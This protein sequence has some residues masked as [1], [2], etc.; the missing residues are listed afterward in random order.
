MANRPTLVTL[1][2]ST[3]LL[4]MLVLASDSALSG[5][6]EARGHK[7]VGDTVELVY[8]WKP[9]LTLYVEASSGRI[10][11]HFLPEPQRS[12]FSIRYV[13]S[14]VAREG[15]LYVTFSD[16]TTERGTPAG[17]DKASIE[18]MTQLT[19]LVPDFLVSSEG[20]FLRIENGAV[21]S[22]RMRKILSSA[23][24]SL[25]S[26]R[27]LE[28]GV[29]M[30]SS[31]PILNAAAASQWERIVGYWVGRRLEIGV[32]YEAKGF[33]PQPMMPNAA[34]AVTT[35]W[36]ATRR[37]PCETGATTSKCIELVLTSETDGD[38]FK[39]LARKLAEKSG[40]EAERKKLESLQVT[41][42]K[43]ESR[44]ITEPDTLIPHYFEIRKTFEARTGPNEAD[45]D[46]RI[47]YQE[48]SFRSK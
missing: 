11:R 28:Q 7:S 1:S 29:E 35:R 45:R 32:K 47:D 41:M 31:E 2:I 20:D 4:S 19:G 9:N 17:G 5:G 34:M 18:A 42:I 15:N 46:G 25:Q 13:L 14:T 10:R 30:L 3:A 43:E 44:L 37:V 6:A 12:S 33:V 27:S 40:D 21:A 39:E 26:S 36:G 16:L 48:S 8:A 23:I 38:D 24:S 22:V